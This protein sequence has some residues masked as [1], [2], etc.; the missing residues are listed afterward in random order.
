MA[1]EEEPGR[2]QSRRSFLDTVLG[3]A[4]SGSGLLAAYGIYSYLV[5]P[6]AGADREGEAVEIGTAA[7]LPEG[8]GRVYA[9]RDIPAIV[10]HTKEGFVA[11]DATCTHLGCLVKWDADRGQIACPCH[12]GIFDLKG[13]VLSGPPPRP[14]TPLRVEVVGDKLMIRS[15]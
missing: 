3:A 5:P 15:A 8:D 4:F 10:I 2:K 7:E 13:N 12:A 9:Y 6:E 11:F 14:L 1:E